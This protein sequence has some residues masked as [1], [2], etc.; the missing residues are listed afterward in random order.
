MKAPSIMITKR[1]ADRLDLLLE[2]LSGKTFPGKAQ[3]EAELSRAS[4]VDSKDVP[5]N[6][7]TMNSTVVFRTSDGKEFSLKLVY[8]QDSDGSPEK[9]SILA[10]IGSAILGLKEGDSIAWSVH[11]GTSVEV[12]IIR[13]AEQPERDGNYSL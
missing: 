3:L 5:P 11:G 2:G 8:P 7:V 4:I 9:L 10:P 13:V 1:D 12:K 6:V